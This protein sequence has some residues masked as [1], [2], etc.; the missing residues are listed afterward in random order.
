MT[1]FPRGRGIKA[2]ALLASLGLLLS[3][4]SGDGGGGGS[5]LT[6][7]GPDVLD[8]LDE[9]VQVEFWHSMD[10]T[11]G[12]VLDELIEG[13]NAENEGRVEVTGSF[14]GDY[15]TALA[16]HRAA[17]QQGETAE[18]IMIYDLGTQFMIDSGQTVP[19]QSFLDEDDYDTSTVEEALLNYFTV[20]GEL[21]SFP[22]NNS[23]PLMYVNR[24]AFEEA[25]L[26]PDSPPTDLEEIRAAAEELT[27]TDDDGTVVQ[28]GFGAAVYGWFIEQFM[29]RA[30]VPYCDG[31]NGRDGRAT[32]VLFD[33]PKVIELVEWWDQMIEDDLAVQIGRNTDDGQA[34]FT[35]GRAAM[36][37]ESTGSLGGFIE[38]SDFEVGAGYF[39]LVGPDD[40]GGSIIGGA[41][42]WVNG[43]GHS[44]EEVR[45]SW[46]FVRYLLTP[47]AQSVWHAGTGYLAV[48]T[49]GYDGPEAQERAEESPQ[50]SVAASQ[51]ADSEINE[52]TAG[53]MMGVMSE[54]RVAAE[55]GWEAALTSDATAEEAM[56]EAARGVS[57]TID[58]YNESVED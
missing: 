1:T 17:I 14:Q 56:S 3:A 30:A 28:Y 22:F 39:P 6:A 52:N 21:R 48:N 45:G 33:D 29:A 15:D 13:F 5:D 8:G 51:L 9:A 42:L 2:A 18:L 38:Q 20:E 44:P 57:G 34:A 36:T 10:A 12:Q 25:G 54:A 53:C 32:E 23:T 27:V 19:A 49:E 24:D 40:P 55:E 58:E 43:E 26:D 35:S 11:N 4:C 31:A 37:L 46:E 16:G 50:F 47:E 7:P 41:S